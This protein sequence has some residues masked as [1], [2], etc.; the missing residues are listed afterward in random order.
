MTPSDWESVGELLYADSRAAFSRFSQKHLGTTCSHVSYHCDPDNG[1]AL[2]GFDTPENSLRVAR[3]RQDERLPHIRE[4][5]ERTPWNQADAQRF[6]ERQSLLPLNL[7]SDGLAFPEEVIWRFP[8][9]LE[10]AERYAEA[11]GARGANVT[12]D[13]DPLRAAV[14]LCVWRQVERLDADKAFDALPLARPCLVSYQDHDR[15]LARWC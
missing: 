5:L 15:P 4:M 8:K 7:S 9:W 6:L 11:A 14:A 13:D 12:V 3:L 10:L 2:L 1:Y